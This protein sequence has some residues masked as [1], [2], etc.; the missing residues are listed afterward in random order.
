MFVFFLVQEDVMRGSEVYAY[1]ERGSNFVKTKRGKGG[2]WDAI[3]VLGGRGRMC[4]GNG[5]CVKM[6]E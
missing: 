6:N 2:S 5:E 3:F 1:S 4:T